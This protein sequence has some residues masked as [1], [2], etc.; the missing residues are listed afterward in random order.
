VD[1]AVALRE[2]DAVRKRIESG[3][4]RPDSPFELAVMSAMLLTWAKRCG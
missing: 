1:P 2:T 3:R 4:L